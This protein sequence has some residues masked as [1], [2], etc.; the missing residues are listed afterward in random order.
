MKNL[1][2]LSLSILISCS[3]GDVPETSIIDAQDTFDYKK[4]I[5]KYS[6]D[7]RICFE[8]YTPSANKISLKTVLLVHPNGD[9]TKKQFYSNQKLTEELSGCLN[10]VTKQIEFPSSQNGGTIQVTHQMNFKL[11]K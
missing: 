10:A 2:L 4:E 5:E 9:I 3:S 6:N 11:R 7:F 8:R 1:L